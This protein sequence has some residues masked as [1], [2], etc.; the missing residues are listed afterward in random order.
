[1]RPKRKHGPSVSQSNYTNFCM[2]AL[3]YLYNAVLLI[4][5]S[6][7]MSNFSQ[8]R[9]VRRQIIVYP[10]IQTVIFSVLHSRK[11]E[12]RLRLQLLREH[13]C[14]L[15]NS[16]FITGSFIRYRHLKITIFDLSRY[17]TFSCGLMQPR[18]FSIKFRQVFD[19][20]VRIPFYH[21]QFY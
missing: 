20:M 5:V 14:G 9:N 1:M 12:L 16:F 3:L 2:L 17:G 19:K 8:L 18:L 6:H 13:F 7:E 11:S 21:R 10:R 4:S 15:W